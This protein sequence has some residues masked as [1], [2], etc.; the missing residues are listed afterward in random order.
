MVERNFW[1]GSEPTRKR[2]NCSCGGE[3]VL[4]VRRNFPFGR[5]SK[6]RSIRFYKCKACKKIEMLNKSSGGKNEKIRRK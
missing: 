6:G 2:T 5:N 3:A 4:V 1:K